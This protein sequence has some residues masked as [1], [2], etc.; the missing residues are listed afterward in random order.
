MFEIV[1][2][3]TCREQGT[4]EEL[5]AKVPFLS[6]SSDQWLGQ[7]Y[8]FWTELDIWAK[9][10]LGDADKVISQYRLALP[11]DNMLDLVG[12]LEDQY[13]FSLIVDQFKKGKLGRAYRERFDDA[14][15]IS[16]LIMWLREE[17]VNKIKGIFPYWAVRAKDA[18]GKRR[19]PY[20]KRR[21]EELLLVERHQMC[22][23][24]EYKD[25]V[26]EF[27]KFTYPEH[28]TDD[29]EIGELA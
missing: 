17:N 2:F 22:V 12:S 25:K 15:N 14:F 26:I 28:F 20:R 27:E 1:G 21:P 3:H 24:A 8:Y 23:Y 13:E 19:V 11:R 9:D 7:G 5:L 10:W 16:S 29:L 6:R 18:A 4:K